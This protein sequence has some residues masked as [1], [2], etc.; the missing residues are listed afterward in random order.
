MSS[1]EL[2]RSRFLVLTFARLVG[3]GT[4]LLGVAVMYTDLLRDGGWPQL[5]AIIAIVGAFAILLM[6]RILRQAWERQDGRGVELP[7]HGPTQSP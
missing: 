7:R 1:D 2:W 6:P 3:L 5:G 4:F